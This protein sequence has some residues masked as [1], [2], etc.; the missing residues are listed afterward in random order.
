MAAIEPRRPVHLAVLLGLS[1]GAYAVSLAGVTALQSETDRQANDVRAP[2]DA[3]AAAISTSHDRLQDD[4]DQAAGAYTEVAARYAQLSSG[5]DTMEAALDRLAGRV[6][7]VTGAANALPAHV[8]LPHIKVTVPR[9][10]APV[11]HA[12]TGA[13]G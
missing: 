4:L 6:T 1:A 13:S 3:A 9:T 8:S 5:L 11:T 12:S 2:I 7:K 10:S